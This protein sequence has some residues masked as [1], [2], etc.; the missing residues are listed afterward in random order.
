MIFIIYPKFELRASKNKFDFK[1]N[2]ILSGIKF[3]IVIFS[4][5]ELFLNKLEVECLLLSPTFPS[6]P[7]G[8][9]RLTP[10][11]PTREKS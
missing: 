1:T 10:S 7:L 9:T 5:E 8:G 6:T 3:L 11:S 4:L 2:S